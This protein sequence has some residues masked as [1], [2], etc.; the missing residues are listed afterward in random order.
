VKAIIFDAYGTLLDV[1]GAM[2]EHAAALG[3]N[4]QAISQEWRT[5][6]LEY[7][8]IATLAGSYRDFWTITLDALRW[9][10]AKHGIADAALLEQVA[11]AYRR[12]PA[13][14]E[15]VETIAA[16]RQRG[17]GCAILSNGEPVMLADAVRAAGLADVLDDVLSVD[18]IRHYKPLPAVYQLATSRFAAAPGELGFVSS[19]AWDAYGA[20][21][22]GCRVF[23]VNRQDLPVE[24]ALDRVATILPDL[25]KLPALV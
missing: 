19:N 21:Q 10:A 14:P 22:F 23:W 3:P 2:Q 11:Q 25:R 13:Y 5:K 18:A 8:W 1:H 6:Q 7:S 15:A 16:L 12:L 4:W 17:L 20:Q 24:Y 9:A